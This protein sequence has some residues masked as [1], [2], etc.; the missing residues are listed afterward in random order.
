ME[1]LTPFRA[2]C[3][4]ADGLQMRFFRIIDGRPRTV[5]FG[6]GHGC[7]DA[8]DVAS[9]VRA[10]AETVILV[11]DPP[12]T[13]PPALQ[14][15][16]VV[17]LWQVIDHDDADTLLV[18]PEYL[19]EAATGSPATS[20]TPREARHRRRGDRNEAI[21]ALTNALMQFLSNA[22]SQLTH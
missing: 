15:G 10:T 13:T 9:R 5:Y 18:S 7:P 19:T 20:P 8:S 11:S 14:T 4:A 1:W 17:L 21:A 3:N 16:R 6:R 2:S 22:Q 12:A